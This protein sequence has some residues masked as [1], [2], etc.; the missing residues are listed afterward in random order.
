MGKKKPL[1]KS[2]ERANAPRTKPAADSAK[3]RLVRYEN[4]QGIKLFD[5]WLDALHDEY[6]QSVIAKGVTLMKMGNFGHTRRVGKGVQEKKIDVAPGYRI[7]YA[8]YGPVVV[9]LIC[10]GD[11]SDQD[12]DIQFAQKCWA[13]WKQQ[14]KEKKR[15]T[16]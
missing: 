8:H 6:A 11:K 13:R 12:R 7:Y 14:Q 5:E 9:Q 4:E 3:Y 16:R 2:R 1:H 15:E 10:G